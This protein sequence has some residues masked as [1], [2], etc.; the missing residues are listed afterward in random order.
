MW[1]NIKFCN[2]REELCDK[3]KPLGELYLGVFRSYFQMLQNTIFF[4]QKRESV[5]D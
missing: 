3:V 2:I 5:K 1:K 4:R